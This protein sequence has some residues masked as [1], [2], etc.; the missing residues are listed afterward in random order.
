[1]DDK[2]IEE[3]AT[4]AKKKPVFEGFR[5]PEKPNKNFYHVPNEWTDIT[6]EIT[7][8]AELKVIEY[9]MR[10]TWGFKEYGKFKKITTDEFMHGRKLG[11]GVTRMDKGTR[12]SNR[13]VID[14]LR[15]AIEHGYVV[16]QTDKRGNKL[17][18]LKMQE[19]IPA[20][21]NLHSEDCEDSSQDLCN[22]F[23]DT[24]NN[25]HSHSEEPSQTLEK[26]TSARN[27]LKETGKESAAP[28][29]AQQT[30]TSF[31]PET[32][33]SPLPQKKLIENWFTYFDQLY[34]KKS[35]IANY[36]YSRRDTKIKDAII[37]LMDTGATFEQVE[38]VFNDIWDDKDAF[39]QE[40]KGKVWVVESQF[41]TRVAKINAPA[42]KR[43]T[44]T[45]T[46]NYTED[47]IGASA[48]EAKP[49]LE[50]QAAPEQP[51]PDQEQATQPAK[52]KYEPKLDQA[53]VYT[54][55]ETKRPA[56]PRTAYGR[57]LQAE[58][59]RSMK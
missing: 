15:A 28:T 25:L 50:S 14:G 13:S 6:A 57:R 8:L 9:I 48:Q 36:R 47:R 49:V 10:H 38:F 23:T 21:K 41:A 44:V 2:N 12:L 34:Q 1:M 33:S 43:R 5:K 20:V 16:C 17:Y 11:D 29:S 26:E 37:K 24:V 52:P 51:T 3:T 31:Q 35:G 39:W 27:F 58:Q 55:L 45:G 7:N 22:I 18:A 46:T 53:P 59:E 42:Q 54:R 32:S 56:R 40:H 19:P 4:P 30:P